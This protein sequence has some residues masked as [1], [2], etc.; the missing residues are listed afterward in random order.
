MQVRWGRGE[1][2]EAV[3]NYRFVWEVASDV[4]SSHQASWESQVCVN[5]EEEVTFE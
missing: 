5:P 4:D 1:G 3:Y 2:H